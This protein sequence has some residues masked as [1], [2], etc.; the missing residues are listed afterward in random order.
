MQP[1]GDPG[2][3]LYGDSDEAG[4]MH[5]M[6][7]PRIGSCPA[8]NAAED[9]DIPPDSTSSLAR[10]GDADAFGLLFQRHYPRILD[11]LYRQT[12]R[13]ATAEEL[14]SNMFYAAFAGWG[15]SR[16]GPVSALAVPD[17]DQ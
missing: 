9:R 2:I 6:E 11:Y 3:F 14:T 12:L 7:N 5:I 10:D 4:E 17:C 1:A 8:A 15:I 13:A 16:R